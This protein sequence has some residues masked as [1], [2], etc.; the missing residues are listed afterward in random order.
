MEL[1]GILWIVT[2]CVGF[3]MLYCWSLPPLPPRPKRQKADKPLRLRGGG[4][5]GLATGL[6]DVMIT[7][8]WVNH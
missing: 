5:N 8:M 6:V 4:D 2:L 7:D 1:L 3:P